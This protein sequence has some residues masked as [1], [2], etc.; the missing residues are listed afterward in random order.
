MIYNSEIRYEIRNYTIELLHKMYNSGDLLLENDFSREFLWK[1]KE[2]IELIETIFRNIPLPLI[3]LY[4]DETGRYQ[5]IDG[6]QRL[7]TIFDFLDNK[8]QLNQLYYFS[9]FSKK[10]FEDIESRS[11]YLFE[12]Y[13]LICYILRPPIPNKLI[14]DIFI[15]LNTKG[16]RANE[17]ELRRSMYRGEAID[18]L[19]KCTSLPIFKE[20]TRNKSG[21]QRGK[22]EE[23]VL[24]FFA[25]YIWLHFEKFE[26]EGINDL[27]N[28]TIRYIHDNINISYELFDIFKYGLERAVNIFGYNCFC[29]EKKIPHSYFN[30]VLFETLCNL[31]S[32]KQ[33]NNTEILT[34]YEKIKTDYKFINTIDKNTYKN[35]MFRYKII[36]QFK[37]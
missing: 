24:K 15:L 18:L 11:Q 10:K 17:H 31:A 16:R 23:I 32:F 9:N 7:Q 20:I 8:F 22:D 29:V 13:S 28:K 1:N 6:K 35:L 27:L 30:S 37:N 2:K 3:Y 34:I 33:K 14:N 5:I 4:Q 21:F 25:M 26:F 19:K 36:E 12:N